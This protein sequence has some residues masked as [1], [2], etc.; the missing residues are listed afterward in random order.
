MWLV[1]GLAMILLF[2]LF[3]KPP[4]QQAT[5]MTYSE[6]WAS[7]ENGAIRDVSIQGEK[8]IGAGP[9]GRTF[10]TVAPKDAE[11]I[12]MLRQSGVD[13]SVKSP[14]ATPW[15][16]SVF[17]SWFPMLLLIGVWIF[18]MRQMQ[19][20]GKG[21]PLSFGKTKAKLLEGGAVKVTFKDVAGIDEAKEE[22]EEI[23]DFLRDPQK[24]QG[25]VAC[26]LTG[27]WENFA[28]KS[29]SR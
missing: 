21:G 1:I 23:I 22:L 14:Q 7:I 24:S 26:R 18:F 9:D 25:C 8:L 15:Y 5:T 11:L 16:L 29:H 2:N 27:Y 10:A 6:F 12:P 28:G 17:I 20:G 4:A 19:M 3:S 13:I